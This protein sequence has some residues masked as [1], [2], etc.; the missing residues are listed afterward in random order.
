MTTQNATISGL[1]ER[2]VLLAFLTFVLLTGGAAVAIRMT[3]VELAPFYVGAARFGLGALVFWV[4][5]LY[6]GIPLPTG[7]AL[8]G[9]V[10][11]GALTIGL[12]FVLIAWGLVGTPASRAQTLMA[13]VPLLTLFLS[14][15]HGLEAITRRGIF[16]SLL[17]AGGIV[18]MVGGTS[19]GQVSLA[20]MAA[21][22]FGALFLAEGGVLIK[23]LP[24]NPPI[25]TNAI[26][27]SVGGV[28]LGV[29]S[30]ISGERWAVPAQG[31]TWAA[32]I[33]LVIFVTIVSF[34][35]YMFV[36]QSWSA[37]GTS[38][39]F[40]MTPLVTTVVAVSLAGEAI[41]QNFL[42]GAVLVLAGVLIG[43]LV[44][45]PTKTAAVEEC[46]DRSGQMVP[47][48]M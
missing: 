29:T 44:P 32:F 46:K 8:L 26:A 24:P 39:A 33:Y 9:A 10:L 47:R 4:L 12:A 42:L 28:I 16:G 45:S 38:Y 7:Q 19:A 22:L 14:S 21:I 34:L 3:Y 43:A 2:R 37:S 35:L 5:V 48:C 23:K 1:P 40:V 18:V 13:T 36:L 30:L 41:T 17:A 15:L 27:L 6:K 25:M 11:F 31:D 20:H